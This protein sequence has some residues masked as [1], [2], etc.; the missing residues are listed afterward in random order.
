MQF[1]EVLLEQL[2][3]QKN[4]KYCV[5]IAGTLSDIFHILIEYHH[6]N[7]EIVPIQRPRLLFFPIPFHARL[8]QFPYLEEIKN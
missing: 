6:I 7:A 2:Q 3:Q 5:Y 1:M 4:V 8:S